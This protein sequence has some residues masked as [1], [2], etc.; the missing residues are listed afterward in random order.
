MACIAQPA[1]FGGDGS[2]S[3]RDRKD[4]S[5]HLPARVLKFRAGTSGIDKASWLLA[6]FFL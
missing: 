6:A 3:F 2:P 5:A 4:L 1:Y